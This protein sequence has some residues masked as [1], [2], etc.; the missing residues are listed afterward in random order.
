[1]MF[2]ISDLAPLMTTS[3]VCALARVSKRTLSRRMA[4]RELDLQPRARGREMLFRRQDV[5]RALGLIDDTQDGMAP[6]AP[7]KS[8]WGKADAEAIMKARKAQ[9]GRGRTKPTTSVGSAQIRP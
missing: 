2:N 8:T 7:P 4:T 9:R 1:M 3:E 6:G 5:V